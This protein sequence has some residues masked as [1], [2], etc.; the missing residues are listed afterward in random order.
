VKRGQT[1]LRP[2]NAST[3][4]FRNPADHTYFSCVLSLGSNDLD[5]PLIS[6]SLISELHYH[7]DI[8]YIILFHGAVDDGTAGRGCDSRRSLYGL[9]PITAR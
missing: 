6:L 4:G 1:E 8:T 2:G 3:Q 5:N 9:A 7:Y